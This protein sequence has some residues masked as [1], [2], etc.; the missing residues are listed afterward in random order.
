MC[1]GGKNFNPL[2][3]LDL[4]GQAKRDDARDMQMAA[5]QKQMEALAAQQASALQNA[6]DVTQATMIA[7]EQVAAARNSAA[8]R[9]SR[10]PL[11]LSVS[12]AATPGGSS[13]LNVPV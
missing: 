2:D 4:S 13:G 6:K 9:S 7:P 8:V 3:L 5:Q 1:I 11:R 12:P 10:N